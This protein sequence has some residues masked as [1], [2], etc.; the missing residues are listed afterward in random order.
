MSKIGQ[1][2]FTSNLTTLRKMRGLTQ[3][4][5][6][7]KSNISMRKY[8][9]LESFEASPSL[10]D[11]YSLATALEVETQK[12]INQANDC[13][14]T[15]GTDREK[16][17]NDQDENA[18]IFLNFLDEYIIP[19]Y[20]SDNSKMINIDKVLGDTHFINH[21]LPMAITNFKVNVHNKKYALEKY[22]KEEQFSGYVGESFPVPNILLAHFNRIL[23]IQENFYYF[24]N[25]Q[26]PGA[27]IEEKDVWYVLGHVHRIEEN[28]FAVVVK[29][30]SKWKTL[31]SNP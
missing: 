5:I 4:Q 7:L 24:S 8:Q 10:H 12:L 9:R 23:N 20:G 14:H 11:I 2:T 25:S 1:I 18:I 22:G 26:L 29:L 15:F 17:Q 21:N 30:K 16:I 19:T 28:Y 31:E 13:F 3:E 27:T 6:A